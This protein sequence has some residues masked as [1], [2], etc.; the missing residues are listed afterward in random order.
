MLIDAEIHR[1]HNCMLKL[2]EF[3]F[4]KIF[5]PMENELF[6]ETYL[7]GTFSLKKYQGLARISQLRMLSNLLDVFKDKFFS[8]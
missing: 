6:F 4:Q 1:L 8:N 2:L 3:I 5:F 7:V